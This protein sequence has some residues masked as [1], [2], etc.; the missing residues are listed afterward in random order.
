RI[1]RA[2]KKREPFEN[3]DY[4]AALGT[5]A[6]LR[7]LGKVDDEIAELE[8][9]LAAAIGTT[10]DVSPSEAQNVIDLWPTLSV[11]AQREVISAMVDSVFVSRGGRGAPLRDRVAIYW[12]GDKVPIERPFRRSPKRGRCSTRVIVPRWR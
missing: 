4:V 12:H 5:D 3:P 8:A 10:T 6:A 9:E 7:A 11:D 2:R 1:A